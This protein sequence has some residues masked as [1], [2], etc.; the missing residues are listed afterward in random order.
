MAVSSFRPLKYL[1]AWCAR[2]GSTSATSPLNR[3]RTCHWAEKNLDTSPARRYRPDLSRA[4]GERVDSQP[5]QLKKFVPLLPDSASCKSVLPLQTGQTASPEGHFPSTCVS[6]GQRGK[7]EILWPGATHSQRGKALLAPKTK[8]RTSAG[9]FLQRR[10]GGS[11][12][13]S[14]SRSFFRGVSA[15]GA[16]AEALRV[17]P[18]VGSGAPRSNG[19]FPANGRGM[20]VSASALPGLLKI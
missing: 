15:G 13:A 18:T 4:A 14:H 11:R 19:G 7:L 8:E 12:N 17:P 10:D 9:S 2:K 5:G 6:A 20:H 1:F 3:K 16:A